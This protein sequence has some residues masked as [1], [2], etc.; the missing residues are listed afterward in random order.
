MMTRNNLWNYLDDSRHE[1]EQRNVIHIF[2]VNEKKRIRYPLQ[3]LLKADQNLQLV[4]TSNDGMMTT[5]QVEFLQP[6][7][8]LVNM[9]MP[10]RNELKAIQNIFESFPKCKIL[11]ISSQE[12]SEDKNKALLAGAK[13]YLLE[14]TPSK[15]IFNAIRTMYSGQS[16]IEPILLEKMYPNDLE[17][18]STIEYLSLSHLNNFGVNYKKL[19]FYKVSAIVFISSILT[20]CGISAYTIQHLRTTFNVAASATEKN[21]LSVATVTALGHLQPKGEVIK[22]S[23]PVPLGGIRIEKL[24]VQEEDRVKKGQVIA[25]LSSRDYLLTALEEA[26]GKLRV[27]N[28]NFSRVK[29]GAQQGEIMAKRADIARLMAIRQG[30]IQAQTAAVSKLQTELRNAEAEEKR[31]QALYLEGAISSSLW[32]SK[33]LN[34]AIAQESLQEARAVLTR[35]QQSSQQQINE[36]SANLDRISEIR[37]VDLEVAKADVSRA[38]A[39]MQGA[40]VNLKQS[41]VK[42]PLDG[43]VFKIHAHPGELISND[44]IIDIAQNGQMSA[45]VE[46]YQTDIGKVRLGQRVSLANNSLPSRLY[47]RVDRLGLQIQR[48]NLINADPSTNIDSRVVEVHVLLDKVSS[49]KAAKLTNMQVKVVITL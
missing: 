15:E 3:V 16:Y 36:A 25:V 45:V 49:E 43:Q 9:D 30:D 18:D 48:Q 20:V 44:G 11:V 29:A 23:A 6:D 5:R 19:S 39:A 26:K 33:H 27:S 31:Y 8:V 24:F 22:L 38:T 2:L 40:E 47:G 46:V 7:I 21:E 35:I 34:S 12:N 10:E 41:Y 1:K 13:N 37:P 14:N 4:G 17:S 42:S 28:A 32:D